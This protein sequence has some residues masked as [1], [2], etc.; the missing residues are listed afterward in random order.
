[1]ALNTSTISLSSLDDSQRDA[2]N[3]SH[4]QT[5]ETIIELEQ[6]MDKLSCELLDLQGKGTIL[7]S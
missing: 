2:T 7:I 5:H 4:D 3:Q 6:E 1:M